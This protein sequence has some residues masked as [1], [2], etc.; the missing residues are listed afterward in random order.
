M[1][2]LLVGLT[3]FWSMEVGS[4]FKA[5]VVSALGAFLVASENKEGKI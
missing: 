2:N 5:A 1:S 4:A 3:P